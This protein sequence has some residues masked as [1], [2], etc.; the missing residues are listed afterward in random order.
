MVEFTANEKRVL[1]A[2]LRLNRWAST[3]E[4]AKYADQMGWATAN[5]ILRDLETKEIVYK[6]KVKNSVKWRIC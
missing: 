1:R 4:I 5:D 6:R 3:N 2:M